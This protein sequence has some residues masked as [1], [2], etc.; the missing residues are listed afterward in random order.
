MPDRHPLD[1]CDDR[2]LDKLLDSALASYVDQE[3]DASLRT[4]ILACAAEVAPRPRRLWLLAP[5]GTCAAA[6]LLA[7]LLHPA[8]RAP[9]DRSSKASAPPPA[10]SA[11]KLDRTLIGSAHP[12]LIAATRHSDN[13]RKPTPRRRSLAS[14]PLTEEE[15]TLLRFAQQHPEQAREVLS[16]PPSGPIHIDPVVITPIQIAALSASQPDAH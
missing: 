1:H 13:R 8:S 7:L 12:H 4:R 9:E 2:E 6:I 16:P 5:A 15:A 11:A 14:A 10:A 3:P